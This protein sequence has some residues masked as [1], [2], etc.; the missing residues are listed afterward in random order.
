MSSPFFHKEPDSKDTRIHA[1]TAIE[2]NQELD[3]LKIY[4]PNCSKDWCV[5]NKNLPQEI[6]KTADPNHGELW[7]KTEDLEKRTLRVFSLLSDKEF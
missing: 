4:E 5:S 1:Y 6:I 2:Y 3:A 7:I